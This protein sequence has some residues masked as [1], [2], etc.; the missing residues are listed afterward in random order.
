MPE[1][2]SSSLAGQDARDDDAAPASLLDW[3]SH[4]CQVNTVSLDELLA[5]YNVA[6]FLDAANPAHL[7]PVLPAIADTW[8][9]MLSAGQDLRRVITFRSAD[10]RRWGSVDTWRSGT[11]TW[12]VQHLAANGGGV[13]SR[14]CIV[15]A[16]GR[17]LAD[18]T[19]IAAESFF[20]P[21]N[22]FSRR[23]PRRQR[24]GRRPGRRRVLASRVVRPRRAPSRGQPARLRSEN[25][26]S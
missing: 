8:E 23:C 17:C 26:H 9:R 21:S 19:F 2:A 15:S 25:A 12:A 5:M 6:G 24:S 18:P 1:P 11:G 16:V 10:G 3:A 22:P 14:A 7:A 4:R 13:G 20:R